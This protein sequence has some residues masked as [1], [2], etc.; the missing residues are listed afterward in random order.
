MFLQLSDEGSMLL[1]ILLFGAGALEVAQLGDLRAQ[2]SEDAVE[3][4]IATVVGVGSLVVRSE[5]GGGRMERLSRSFPFLRVA[6]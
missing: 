6:R 5:S 4:S 3:Q 2:V 1:E